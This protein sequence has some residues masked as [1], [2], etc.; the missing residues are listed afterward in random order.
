MGLPAPGPSIVA[1]D[2]RSELPGIRNPRHVKHEGTSPERHPLPRTRLVH[3]NVPSLTSCANPQSLLFS[4]NI[5][6]LPPAPTARLATP[7]LASY[8][9]PPACASSKFTGRIG[10]HAFVSRLLRVGSLCVCA[11]SLVVALIPICSQSAKDPLSVHRV[12]FVYGSIHH[13][14]SPVYNG[15]TSS[16]P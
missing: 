1:H 6:H 15:C 13:S 8:L 3:P 9:Y 11:L 7:T 14:I 10:A 2:L 5:P 16:S 12:V 4:L